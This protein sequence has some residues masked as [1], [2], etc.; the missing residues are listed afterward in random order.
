MYSHVFYVT[1]SVYPQRTTDSIREVKIPR[2][3]FTGT[4]DIDVQDIPE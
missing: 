2:F 4:S 3:R 1:P